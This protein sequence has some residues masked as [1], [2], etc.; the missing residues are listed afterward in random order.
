M[1][2]SVSRAVGVSVA[3]TSPASAAFDDRAIAKEPALVRV[4][5]GVDAQAAGDPDAG[6][7]C[8]SVSAKSPA[9]VRCADSIETVAVFGHEVAGQVVGQRRV[10]RFEAVAP[11]DVGADVQARAA[12]RGARR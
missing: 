1:P 10:E 12:R 5:D 3:A 9:A 4:P 7:T 11:L 8:A 6:A 2:V